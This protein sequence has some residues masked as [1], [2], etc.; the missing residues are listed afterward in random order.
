MSL[1]FNPFSFILFLAALPT[2]IITAILVKRPGA[3]RQFSYVMAVT[4]IWAFAYGLELMSHTLD[5]MLFWVKVEY[6]GVALIPGLLIQFTLAF[7]GREALIRPKNQWMWYVV[8]AITL[9][10]VLTTPMHALHY[11]NP[12]VNQSGPF[13]LLQFEAGPWYWI[14]TAY[15]YGAMIWSLRELVRRYLSTA[16]LYKQQALMIIL[17]SILPW[18]VNLMYLLDFRPFGSLDLTPF[19]FLAT[20]SVIAYGLLKFRLFELLPIARDKLVEGMTDGVMVLDVLGQV[21]DANPMM[22]KILNVPMEDLIGRNPA[23]FLP[24]SDSLTRL[25]GQNEESRT[26]LTL[27][28]ADNPIYLQIQMTPIID[29]E[30]NNDRNGTLLV[31]RDVTDQERFERE[32]LI[33]KSK[34]VE[35]DRLKTAFLANVSHEIRNPM[36]AIMGFAEILRD[37]DTS[38]ADRIRYSEIISQSSKRLLNL[39]NDIIDLSKLE[40]GHDQ[41][42]FHAA[43][44]L[45]VV[46]EVVTLFGPESQRKSI[47]IIVESELQPEEHVVETDHQKLRQILTNLLSNALRFTDE[48]SVTVRIR[49]VSKFL[50]LSVKDT[51]VGIDPKFHSVIFERFRQAD[52]RSPRHVGGT[53]LGLALS[54]AYA[55]LI[56]G[57]LMV[58]SDK[59]AGSTFTL[60]I[61]YAA[62]SLAPVAEA[63]SGSKPDLPDL[64]GHRILLA[65]D[66]PMNVKYLSVIL[67]KAKAEVITASNGREAVTIASSQDLSLVIMDIMMPEMDG[68]D[69]SRRIRDLKPDLPIVGLSGHAMIEEDKVLKAG[70]THMMTKPVQGAEILKRIGVL[71]KPDARS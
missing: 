33:A 37:P 18:F 28:T 60:R 61:P 38:P 32:L 19:A 70:I 24:D 4:A 13:P 3:P 56:G 41:P 49:R 64:S 8:P 44:I 63:A 40:A 7:T 10:M 62:G 30:R 57:Q 21:V 2:G 14:H 36:H 51:G 17:G 69:A 26:V 46:G 31:W 48:G 39:L 45:D 68:F 55:T 43:N 15:F 58:D 59:G 50:Y 23:D 66:E 47:P 65:E 27:G 11:V 35:S 67:R 42:T 34:A 12:S 6:V 1:D 22:R 9:A 20:G 16:G 52:D 29:R 5:M 54:K 25:I 71:L 53:G